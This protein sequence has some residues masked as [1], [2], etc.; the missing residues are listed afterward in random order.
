MNIERKDSLVNK[1][2]SIKMGY[3]KFVMTNNDNKIILIR[4][5]KLKIMNLKHLDQQRATKN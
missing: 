3:M 5:M 4:E 2:Q 1:I